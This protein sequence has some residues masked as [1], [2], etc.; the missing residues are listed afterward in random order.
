VRAD[1]RRHVVEPDD[2]AIAVILRGPLE[3]GGHLAP[4]TDRR[5]ERIG[6][7]HI[8][9]AGLEPLIDLRFP[10]VISWPAR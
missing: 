7:G 10:F 1:T 3:R 4:A 5:T 2:L 8:T 9:A 6:E